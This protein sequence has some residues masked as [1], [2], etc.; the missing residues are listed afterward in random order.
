MKFVIF[1]FMLSY[2]ISISLCALL[3]KPSQSVPYSIK[4]SKKCYHKQSTF[5]QFL[6]STKL[7][8]KSKSIYSNAKFD[9][10][11]IHFDY[12]YTLPYEEKIIKEFIIPP[13]KTFYESTLKV[14]RVP[15]KINFPQKGEVK[16]Q[17]V[18]IPQ[19]MLSEGVE[20]DILIFITTVRGMKKYEYDKRNKNNSTINNSSNDDVDFLDKYFRNITNKTDNHTLLE[21]EINDGLDGVIGWSYS[22]IQDMFTYRPIVGVMQYVSDIIPDEREIQEA[23]W[24]T[25]HEFN[26][27][28][29]FDTLLYEHFIDNNF[30]KLGINKVLKMKSRLKGLKR[31]IE[32]RKKYFDDLERFLFLD[33]ITNH[34]NIDLEEMKMTLPLQDEYEEIPIPSNFNLSTIIYAINNFSDYTKI[35]ISTPKVLKKAK[36]YF[37]CNSM[38]GVELEHLGGIGSAYSHWSKRILNTEYM[39]ADSYGE[40]Y[41]SSLSLALFEDS[42]WYK[43]D[44]SKAQDIKW[45]KGKG[46]AFLNEKCIE[47]KR[48]NKFLKRNLVYSTKYKNEFCTN[49]NEEQC[50]INRKFRGVCAVREYESKGQIPIEYNYFSKNK[51]YKN[52][53]GGVD[54]FGDYC[55]YPL[56]IRD[57]ES[58][59]PIGNCISGTLLRKE[60]GE[61][62]CEDCRCFHSSLTKS[63]KEGDLK[64]I[65]YETKCK[66]D[67][68]GKNVLVVYIEDKEIICPYK[69]GMLTVE[70]FTGEIE[71]PEYS[72]ICNDEDEIITENEWMFSH[73]SKKLLKFIYSYVL[74]IIK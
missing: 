18:D 53:I 49:F 26:H 3:S 52:D 55:P 70:E 15:G 69:G 39:I 21:W 63:N 19:K 23:I 14:R 36:K 72:M 68:T 64:A 37:N 4:A 8:R 66:R 41:I 61:K 11:R 17:G 44:Y 9:N 51:D 34:D 65:C 59:S 62:I 57:K 56:E 5:P 32:H 54:S 42:G 30:Q 20:A 7:N 1:A 12:T 60:N 71:C 46:C 45:G 50:S 16:C 29:V 27:I 6:S 31:I 58:Y 67:N 2:I 40:N 33:N 35:Y 38:I 73:I 24:T 13:V 10:I 22:C 48:S 43:V 47:E 25:L 74:K 28:F